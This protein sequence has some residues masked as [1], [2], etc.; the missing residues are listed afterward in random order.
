MVSFDSLATGRFSKESPEFYPIS[1]GIVEPVLVTSTMT[2]LNSAYG[3]A[4]GV[5]NCNK[6]FKKKRDSDFRSF[7]MLFVFRGIFYRFFSM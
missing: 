2:K 4:A 7:Y 3:G 5:Y 6:K 1:F